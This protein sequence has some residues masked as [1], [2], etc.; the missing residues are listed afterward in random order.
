MTTVLFSANDG[1]HGV[2]LWITDGTTAGTTMVKHINPGTGDMAKTASGQDR[3]IVWDD[4]AQEVTLYHVELE[5]H[6]VLIANNALA[7]SYRD[8]GNRWLFQNA[9]SGWDQPPR[10][11]RAGD[12]CFICQAPPPTFALS[13][14]LRR[15]GNWAW[16]ATRVCWASPCGKSCCAAVARN[17]RS[18]PTNRL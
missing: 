8:D 5:N 11:A 4:H 6:D 14:A 10:G 2:E 18:R 13:P 12:M 7:E 3:S 1:T 17:A 16:P 9:N 15:R